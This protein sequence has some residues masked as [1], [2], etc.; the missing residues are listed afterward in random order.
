MMKIYIT[1]IKKQYN[2]DVTNKKWNIFMRQQEFED[3][4]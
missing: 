1:I 2:K 3:F 4:N